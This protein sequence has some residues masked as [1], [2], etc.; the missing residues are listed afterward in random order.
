MRCIKPKSSLPIPRTSM[1]RYQISY[2][3]LA[4]L[5]RSAPF[6]LSVPASRSASLSPTPDSTLTVRSEP[7][8]Q[9]QQGAGR[10][11][12]G[13][14][15]WGL[16]EYVLETERECVRENVFVMETV[17]VRERVCERSSVPASTPRPNPR[18]RL[19]GRGP[20]STSSSSESATP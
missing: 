18:E 17:C 7:V 9:T 3:C 13:L 8:R 15:V 10:R 12:L 4:C 11:A 2:G 5:I 20:G 6:L 16:R 1:V 19:E 14:G